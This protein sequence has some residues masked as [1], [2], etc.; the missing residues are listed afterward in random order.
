[1]ERTPGEWKLT[2]PS[3]PNRVSDG[4][5]YAIYVCDDKGH[6]HIIA[7]TYSRTAE[8]TFH[9][10]RANAEFI[11][12]ACNAHDDLLEA[13]E[14]VVSAYEDGEPSKDNLRTNLPKIRA[15]ISKAKKG[16]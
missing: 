10:A 8:K 11:V 7:E 14:A 4:I 2:G 16:T 15:A 9:P 5:D 13:C 12:R 1:M 6:K 3:C